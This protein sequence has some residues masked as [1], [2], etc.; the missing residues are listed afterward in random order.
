MPHVITVEDETVGSLAECCEAMTARGFRPDDPENLDHAARQLRRLG[1]DRS[2]LGD[3]LI[4]ELKRDQRQDS[5]E[6]SYG[7]QVVMLKP[8]GPGNYFMRANIWPS[9]DEHAMRASGG[10]SFVYSQPHDHNFNFLTVGYFGPGYWSN[11]YEYD[12]EQVTGYRGEPVALR[13]IERSRLEEGKIMLYRA[14][15]DVHDQA[16]PD[17]LSIS[18]N[19]M[20]TTGAQAWLDQYGFDLGKNAIGRI[21]SNGSSEAFLRIAVGMG[22]GNA[23]DLAVNFGAQ[24]PSDRMR[25]AAWG[26]LASVERDAA[27]RDAVWREAEHAGSRLVAAEARMRRTELVG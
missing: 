17:A 25:L 1:N 18:I 3:L 20:H 5:G 16:P 4:E 6:N 21:I 12:Y 8:S 22:C 10:G 11:Y 27:A 7:P 2:F 9:E 26:A 24:H 13:F 19:I 23:R 15:I 14:H